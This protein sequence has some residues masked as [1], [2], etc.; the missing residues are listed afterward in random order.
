MLNKN[1]N[2]IFNY[3]WLDMTR[4][5]FSNNDDVSWMIKNINQMQNYNC[6][7]VIINLQL[8][9]TSLFAQRLS[10]KCEFTGLKIG[11]INKQFNL[12]VDKA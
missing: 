12:H 2:L 7:R 5:N 3:F 11:Q 10:S 1:V 6:I 8:T 9:G 4:N